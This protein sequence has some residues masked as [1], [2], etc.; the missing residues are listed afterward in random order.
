MARLLAIGTDG[1]KLI[2]PEN[3]VLTVQYKILEVAAANLGVTRKDPRYEPMAEGRGY[4]PQADIPFSWCGEYVSWCWFSAGI[5]DPDII[6]RNATRGKWRVGENISSFWYGARKLGVAYLA[7]ELA[8][9]QSRAPKALIGAALTIAKPN[10]DHIEIVEDWSVLNAPVVYAGN[11]DGG[12]SVRKTRKLGPGADSI[13]FVTI[14]YPWGLTIENCLATN[15]QMGPAEYEK[16]VT[17][18]I[19]ELGN[20]LGTSTPLSPMRTEFTLGPDES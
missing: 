14:P 13:R 18:V 1:V 8:L 16:A 4:G 17:S 19:T 5:R 10:G 20:A 6:N 3:K 11:S 2:E 15:Q 9:L 7:T 12:I